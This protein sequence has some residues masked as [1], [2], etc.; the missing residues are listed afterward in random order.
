MQVCREWEATACQVN[1]EDVR[2]VL[3]RIGVVLGKDGGALGSWVS[4]HSF[5]LFSLVLLCFFPSRVPSNL[6]CVI[7]LI[8]LSICSKDDPPFYDVCRWSPGDGA[9][10]VASLSSVT[11]IVYAGILVTLFPDRWI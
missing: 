11:D 8:H 5:C 2:L 1:Q 3:L 6:R 9:S 4:F 10:M 7:H